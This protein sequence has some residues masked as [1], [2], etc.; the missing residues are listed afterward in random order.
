MTTLSYFEDHLDDYLAEL[1]ELVEIETPT[2]GVD[3]L[4][5]AADFLT[6]CLSPLAEV[7]TESLDGLGPMLRAH[8]AG[9]GPKL[10]VLAHYDTV[11]PVGSWP[12]LWRPADGRIFGPGVNDMKGGLLF[13]PWL[14]RYLDASGSD[15]P[16]IEILLNPDEEVGSL[17]SI[18]AIRE[19]AARSDFALVLESINSTGSLALARKGSGDFF[20]HIRGRAAHQ[21]AEPE[22]GVNAV[23]EAA[24]QVLRLI[25][26][27]DP[28]RGTTLGPNVISG[29][30]VP[31]IVAERADISIDV[32]TWTVAE[33]HRLEAA[34]RGLEPV[35]D[36]A[37]IEVTGQWNRTPMEATPAS[38]ELCERARH[39]AAGLG[40]KLD[41]VAWGGASDANIAAHAGAATLDGFGPLGDGAHQPTESIVVEALPPRLALF[42]ELVCSL[43]EPPEKWM[44]DEALEQM[45]A[46]RQES[47]WF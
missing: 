36:G 26:L 23:L 42:T 24:H 4:T 19:T 43:A 16:D 39:L 46:R 37:K 17:G 14:L 5:R 34:I 38:R 18:P 3:G 7:T 10:L 30:T 45:R 21:G 12:E 41:A 27:G 44:S 40:I 15:H 25:E 29:G 47:S 33:Q 1:R 9:N 11:W 2:R 8:R 22:L 31:N 13:I 32:R 28:D 6:E 35:L 20:V